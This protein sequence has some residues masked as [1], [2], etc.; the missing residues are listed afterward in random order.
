MFDN[1]L[2][3]FDDQILKPETQDFGQYADGIKNITEAQQKVASEYLQDGSIEDACPPLKALLSIMATGHF[4]GKDVHH[5]EIRAMFTREYL[6]ASDWY[7]TRLK[8]K[9]ERDI[10]L[11]QRH[12]AYLKTF[13]SKTGNTEEAERLGLSHRLEEAVKELARVSSKDYRELLIGTLGAD[14]LGGG[15]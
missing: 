9:Q 6:L 14:P 12:V 2:K 5:P 3:V 7:L 10:R 15:G 13:L 11:W 8:I 4:E 1:P